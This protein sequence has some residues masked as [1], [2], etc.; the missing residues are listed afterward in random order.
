MQAA[1]ITNETR[2]H[3]SV[4]VKDL[5]SI[6]HFEYG[7]P[8]YGSFDGMRFRVAREPMENVHFIPVDKRGH[9]TLHAQAWP[10]PFGYAAADPDTMLSHDADFTQEGLEQTVAW[11]NE[12]HDQV[13]D[14]HTHSRNAANA[15]G[16]E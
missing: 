7:E 5:F 13:A 15:D 16:S 3:M 6:T 10:E 14:A 8:Y 12:V 11:L 4:K 1:T 2:I 9:A